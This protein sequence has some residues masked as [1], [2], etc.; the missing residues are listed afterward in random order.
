MVYRLY[1]LIVRKKKELLAR[2]AMSITPS[3]FCT[4]TN[5]REEWEGRGSSGKFCR[6]E[7]FSVLFS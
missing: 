1:S 4:F 3:Y 6:F 2:C 7:I 5:E